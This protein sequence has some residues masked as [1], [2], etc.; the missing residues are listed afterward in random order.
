[1]LRNVKALI[2]EK[3]YYIFKCDV[4]S[5]VNSLDEEILAETIRDL[6]SEDPGF[7]DFCCWLVLRKKCI[8]NGVVIEKHTAG[9]G[10]MPLSNYFMNIYLMTLDRKLESGVPLYGRY[11]DDIAAFCESEAQRD[12]VRDT[13][14][15][16]LLLKKLTVNPDKT[17]CL[18]KGETIDLLGMAIKGSKITLCKHS[19]LKLKRKMRRAAHRSNLKVRN[20]EISR[21]DA[22]RIFIA[23]YRMLFFGEN[24]PNHKLNWKRWSFSIVNDISSFKELDA[25]VQQCLR[26]ILSGRWG[27][28]RYRVKYGELKALGYKTIVHT[29]YHNR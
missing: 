5:Y 11:G 28:S 18:D 19:L 1:M 10:G 6:N 20:G 12:F 26:F 24:T 2:Q 8:R 17:Y 4:K 14:Q 27:Q 3:D 25:Y 13:V 23:Y 7:A 29:Y 21:E 15:E 9:L 16:E 22:A